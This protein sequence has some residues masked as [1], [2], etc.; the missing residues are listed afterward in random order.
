VIGTCCWSGPLD[1]R[2]VLQEFTQTDGD[3]VL[4]NP[5]ICEF[6]SG[7][8]G[9]HINCCRP[10]H[11]RWG[12]ESQNRKENQLRRS[13]VS[14]ED[15]K[16]LPTIKFSALQELEKKDMEDDKKVTNGKEEI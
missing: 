11:L 15:R 1:V 14:N 12:T 13:F 7:L 2:A 3:V 4:H 6:W 8:T 5:L 16:T 10:T 9:G